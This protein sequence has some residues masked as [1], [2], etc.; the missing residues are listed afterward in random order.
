MKPDHGGMKLG[1]GGVKRGQ[2][3]VKPDHPNTNLTLIEPKK[4]S[5]ASHQ[6]QA[7]PAEPGL[8][9]DPVPTV[10]PEVAP[11][12]QKPEHLPI[13]DAVYRDGI[14]IIR[15]LT[16]LADARARAM[17]G[18]LLKA[19]YDDCARVYGFLREVENLRPA[20]PTAWLWAA[21]KRPR[22]GAA[23]N[24]RD[25][26]ADEKAKVLEK[27]RGWRDQQRGVEIDGSVA[28]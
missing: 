21:A 10:K 4:D 16:G 25:L 20:D 24:R 3:G 8:F 12:P 11:P 9:D 13:R 27:L 15:D 7:K 5:D 23:T 22:Y 28:P 17:L 1:R 6:R 19:A 26:L 18:G 2:V 14:P